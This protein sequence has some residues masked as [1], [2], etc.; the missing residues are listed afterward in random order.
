MKQTIIQLTMR[1]ENEVYKVDIE[2]SKDSVQIGIKEAD[3]KWD[4]L[5]I[6]AEFCDS[7]IDMLQKRKELM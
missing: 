5:T 4:V 7:V 3:E 6:P 2:H 1:V